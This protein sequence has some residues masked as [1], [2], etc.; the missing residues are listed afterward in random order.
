MKLPQWGFFKKID[1]SKKENRLKLFILASGLTVF[2]VI[3]L[4]GAIKVTMQPGFCGKC[5]VMA[6]EYVTWEAS[7]HVQVSC[8]DC[9][10]PPGL[11]NLVVHKV[12]ALKELAMY[13][14]DTYDLPIKMG[15]KL[16]DEVCT[17]C[18]SVFREYTPSGDLI[19]PHE[20]HA[21][22]GIQ[23]VECHSGVA[24]GNILGRGLTKTSDFSQWTAEVGKQQMIKD[25][26]EP[27]M[28]VCMACHAQRKV[29]N[30]C[31][32]C[33]T[34]IT[35]PPDHNVKDFGTTHGKLAKKDIGYCN[36]CHSYAVEGQEIPGVSKVAE[37]ARGNSFC[38][39]CHMQLPQSHGD[40]W[41]IV[42]KN[43][44][45]GN[46]EGCLVCH[47]NL[48]PKKEDKATVTYCQ[49][50]H[51]QPEDVPEVV[52]GKK[53]SE[54]KNSSANEVIKNGNTADYFRMVQSH[55]EDWRKKHP[56]FIKTEGIVK[57]KCFSCHDTSNCSRCHTGTN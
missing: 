17:Q 31:E 8:T 13:A 25:N 48:L 40:D 38:S 53:Q 32:A 24:H 29:T 27:K 19:I 7:S 23:C 4:V 47:N 42:H 10:I 3:A 16:P 6:P 44:A 41:K 43:S 21:S 49:Q 22:K 11:G 57:G 30:A 33:H 55:P 28:N 50:C 9:H 52:T 45:K 5:H 56:D 18:H 12:A 2:L 37:Y 34:S 39:D 54:D 36:K 46:V 1:L 14:T 20:R 35:R 15:H 26:T 51:G